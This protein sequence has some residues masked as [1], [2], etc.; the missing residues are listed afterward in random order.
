VLLIVI[1]TLRADRL[2]VYGNKG[3]LSPFLDELAAR[4]VVFSNT[5]AASSWTVPSIA[6]LFT[7]HY[8]SQHNVATFESKVPDAAVTLAEKLAAYGYVSGGFL[9]NFR[10]TKALGYA[11]GFEYWKIYKGNS[12]TG[13]KVRGN[14]LRADSLRWLESL[15][16][17]QAARPQFLYVH[18]MEPHAPYQPIEPYRSRFIRP[19]DGVDEALANQKVGRINFKAVTWQDLRLLRSLYDGE[20]ASVDAELRELFAVLERRGFLEHAIIVITA[21]HG[22]EFKEHGRMAHGHALYDES[23]RVPLI[24]LAPGHGP[25]VVEENVSLID[26]APT[27]LDL[28]ALPPEPAFEG[29]SLVELI[30]KPSLSGWLRSIGAPAEDVLSELPPTGSKF[31]IRAHSQAIFRKS[32]KL[33]VALQGRPKQEVPEIYD[34]A[35]DPREK[36]PDPPTLTA[37]R[38]TLEAA[39]REK[40]RDLA[41]R[42]DLDRETAPVDEATKEKLRALGYTF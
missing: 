42:V 39:L 40:L 20:V 11:Q 27:I 13:V 10:L 31:D 18:Y 22:E 3:G 21:D 6:S 14:R 15:S 8:P 17:E 32:L 28:L 7:S 33:L 36:M 1:D 37:E 30:D 26:V 19:V 2:G 16:G 35:A 23:I 24:V 38:E 29:R 34:L 9:A 5:F 41:R 12:P 25:G 4:G